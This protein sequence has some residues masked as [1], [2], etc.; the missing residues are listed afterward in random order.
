MP[1]N[2]YYHPESHGLKLFVQT[3]NEALDYAFSMFVVW[4][5][6]AGALFYAEDAGCSCPAPFEDIYEVEQLNTII[7]A[8][9]LQAFF[10]AL[11]TWGELNR[12]DSYGDPAT[13]DTTKVRRK[14]REYMTRAK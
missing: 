1:E 13:V 4:I 7:G 8:N 6:R 9:G 11:T 12:T 5:D 14:V 3:S 2:I 10:D